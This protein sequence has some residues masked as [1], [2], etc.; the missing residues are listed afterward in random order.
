MEAKN[1]EQ[2]VNN[3]ATK[4]Q[5]SPWKIAMRSIINCSAMAFALIGSALYLFASLSYSAVI[6]PGVFKSPG[7][8]IGSGLFS[9]LVLYIVS[10]SLFRISD[11]VCCPKSEVPNTWVFASAK[12]TAVILL[13]FW[14][15]ILLIRFPGNYDPDTIWELLQLY[16]F[17][18]LNDQHPW[19]DTLIFGGFWKMGDVLGSHS[20]S[21]FLFCFIQVFLTA[22]TFG[23]TLR[24]FSKFCP[25]WTL[26]VCLVFLCAF[27]FIP[28]VAQTMMKDSLFAWLF[29]LHVVMLVKIV[30]SRGEVLRDKRYFFSYVFI[31][32]LCCLTKKTGFYIILINT[33]VCMLWIKREEKSSLFGACLAI[34]VLFSVVWETL[35]IPEMGVTKGSGGEA[36]SI[37]FQ[38]VGL[39]LKTHGS[40]LGERDWV[41]IN[42]VFRDGNTISSDYDPL[43]SDSVKNHWD[44]SASSD[45]KFSFFNWYIS[46]GIKHP[47]TYAR[48]ALVQ[49]YPLI[50]PDT[51]YNNRDIESGLFY[52]DNKYNAS[53]AKILGDWSENATEEMIESKLN[54]T[55]SSESGRRVSAS[56]DSFYLKCIEGVPFLFCKALYGFWIPFIAVMQSV[57]QRSMWKFIAL[58]PAVLTTLVL[59]VGP[60][61]LPRY[62]TTSI[63]LIPVEL[64]IMFAD[65]RLPSVG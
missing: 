40:E 53:I 60:V 28:M 39:L 48:A 64:C 33:F 21:L 10:L 46:Q 51:L 43:R 14:I 20:I 26:I 18:P 36:L 4:R 6:A 3:P 27:P 25:S 61:V 22:L 9:F 32:L 29:L 23:Y 17:F 24:Y 56:F 59:A 47:L 49:D 37:P 38:Q 62:M 35:V 2:E 65:S 8:I 1:G 45:K 16:G 44:D 52:I 5:T 11:L 54:T 15:P 7:A 42:G 58:V 57:R 12:R 31:S 63:Y 55:C 13:F 34:V 50:V 19:F 41:V 30:R